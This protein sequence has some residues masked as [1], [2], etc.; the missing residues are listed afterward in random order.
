MK[1]AIKHYRSF[2]EV[3]PKSWHFISLFLNAPFYRG[4]NPA[5]V[6]IY[7][8]VTEPLDLVSPGKSLGKPQRK[9]QREQS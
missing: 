3:H 8:D 2:P 9:R 4:K 7:M 5:A 1:S 6:L